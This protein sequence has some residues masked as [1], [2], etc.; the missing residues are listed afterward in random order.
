[1]EQ[2]YELENVTL[3]PTTTNSGHLG[4]KVNF[5]VI[6][7]CDQ[8]GI[9]ES[10]PIFTSPMEA[11]I[12]KENAKVFSDSGIK[13]VLPLTCELS[14][15]LEYC[16]WIFCAF[17]MKEVR[18]N[19]LRRDMRSVPSQ[20]H[21]CIDAGN[22]HDTGLLNL[23]HELR[24]NYGNQVIIMG[25]NVGCPEI[26]TDYARAGFDYMRVGMASGSLVDPYEYGFHL[27]MASL[28]DKIKLYRRTAAI[29]LPK[30]VKIIADGGIKRPSDIIKALALGADYVMIGHEFAR[31]IEA[32]GPIYKS[33]KTASG[34]YNLDEID[35][36]TV[37]GLPGH[38]A[39]MDGLKRQYHGN[40]SLEMRVLA[41]GYKS[42]DDYIK[43]APK[44][45]VKDTSWKWVD[46]DSNLEEWITEFKRCA[47]YAFMMTGVTGWEDFKR[48]ARYGV[49]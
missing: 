14:V 26:Y 31:V 23:G 48:V 32:Y 40:T 30:T 27:P 20:F 12:G 6:D 9:P 10:L 1:M 46:I 7:A 18:D 25:G 19:F 5:N 8:T 28:L 11:I 47:Y 29:G 42:T 38:R 16:K 33:S 44:F 49:Y 4:D 21:I 35:P 2:F 17:S 15:R 24:K 3:L 41:G 13:P 37:Q 43:T 36:S 34:D 39:K 22:G 45:R